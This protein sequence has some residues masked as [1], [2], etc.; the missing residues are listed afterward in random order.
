MVRS[1]DGRRCGGRGDGG[2]G[3]RG[4]ARVGGGSGGCEA[5]RRRARC[6]GPCGRAA[7]GCTGYGRGGG[8][9]DRGGEELCAGGRDGGRDGRVCALGGGAGRGRRRARRRRERQPGVLEAARER[10]GSC[11]RRFDFRVADVMMRRTAASDAG[12]AAEHD[13]AV[14]RGRGGRADVREAAPARGGRGARVDGR[15]HGARRAARRARE[16]PRQREHRVS[17]YFCS[18]DILALTAGSRR[19]GL[20]WAADSQG[21]RRAARRGRGGG[22]RGARRRGAAQGRVRGRRGGRARAAVD[23]RAG[24][25]G[26]QGARAGERGA[27]FLPLCVPVSSVLTLRTARA[28]A[29][30]RRARELPVQG[31]RGRAARHGAGGADRYHRARRYAALCALIR[32]FFRASFAHAVRRARTRVGRAAAIRPGKPVYRHVFERL[33]NGTPRFPGTGIGTD[34]GTRRRRVRRN[35]GPR[36]RRRAR[37]ARGGHDPRVRGGARRAARARARPSRR[38]LR[39]GEG[40]AMGPRRDRVGG[41]GGPGAAGGVFAAADARGAG[42]CGGRGEAGGG[43]EEGAEAGRVRG[44][45]GSCVM[46][47]MRVSIFRVLLLIVKFF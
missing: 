29:V 14:G 45:C 12:E 33:A 4:R 15:A 38:V 27:R 7:G 34:S 3:R 17:L 2:A 21:A 28:G 30:P 8:A 11:A 37:R 19:G 36:A 39:V 42:C 22:H 26:R 23:A 13:R 40:V 10:C 31:R 35:A 24:V 32:P 18:S 25:G 9:A 1:A 43:A 47:L 6:G 16:R 46:V 41:G 5:P 44:A 20:R